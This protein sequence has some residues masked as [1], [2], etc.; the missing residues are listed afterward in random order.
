MASVYQQDRDFKEAMLALEENHRLL[1]SLLREDTTKE[2]SALDSSYQL[3][4][5]REE[6]GQL[7]Q[8]NKQEKKEL[9]IGLVV[10]VAI[11]VIL[12][13]LWL[14]LRKINRL[15]NELEASNRIKDT[16]FSVIGHDLKGPAGSAIQL[17]DLMEAEDFNEQEFRT[18]ISEVRKQTAASFELLNSLFNWGK[19]QLQGVKVKIEDFDPKP[20]IS[21]NISL[22]TQ[23]AANKKIQISDYTTGDFFIHADPD[24]FDFVIRNLL[25]NAIKFTYEPGSIVVNMK[26]AEDRKNI[27]FS[28]KDSG[29]GV[30]EAKQKEFLKSNMPVAFGTKGEKGSGLGLLLSKDFLKANNGRIWIES[31]E[32]NGATFYFTLPISKAK[33]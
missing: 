2:I 15:N 33:V 10:L 17:F 9:E 26:A 18:M 21:R 25:S 23:Q 19:A 20:L 5:S 12:L 11:L 31:K 1:D 22:L 7:K 6:I 16:L 30:S 27:V 8:S 28:V 4:T 29:T 32:G 14:N 13:L 3:E 24:H